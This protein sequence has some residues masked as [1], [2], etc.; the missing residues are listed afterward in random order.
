MGSEQ[1]CFLGLE[2]VRSGQTTRGICFPPNNMVIFQT[3]LRA[4]L[5]LYSVV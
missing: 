1:M 4:K 3:L 2:G 5:F